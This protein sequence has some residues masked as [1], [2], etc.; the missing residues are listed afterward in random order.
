MTIALTIL[1]FFI[2]MPAALVFV[3]RIPVVLLTGDCGRKATIALAAASLCLTTPLAIMTTNRT[4]AA[5][6][7]Q[8]IEG[9]ATATEVHDTPAIA[10][11]QNYTDPNAA[12][13]IVGNDQD[14]TARSQ[15]AA[16]S[17]QAM[18]FFHT[19]GYDTAIIDA[20]NSEIAPTA[21]WLGEEM[22]RWLY[23]RRNVIIYIVTHGTPEQL[24][25]RCDAGQAI[26]SRQLADWVG[27]LD[28]ERVTVII[29]ACHSGSFIDDLA[30]PGRVIATSTDAQTQA[31]TNEFKAY[32]SEALFNCLADNPDLM[33]CFEVAQN[34]VPASQHPQIWIGW[35]E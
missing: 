19:L 26:S 11:A 33:A 16:T 9:D 8:P 15:I 3:G 10:P 34:G 23:G 20:P 27:M 13:I 28:A 31:I 7:S 30:A 32:F 22:L 1:T 6:T 18:S 25:L 14:F 24:C 29:E 12:L 21:D 17:N 2:A 35:K 5:S 4:V